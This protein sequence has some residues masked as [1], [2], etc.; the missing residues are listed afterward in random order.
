MNILLLGN[1]FD[2]N[3]LFPTSYIN[4]LNTLVFLINADR[5]KIQTIKDVFGNEDLQN[6]DSFIKKCYEKHSRIYDD[7]A[8][9]RDTIE[10]IVTKAEKNQWFKYLS[11]SV[12]VNMTWID[13]EKEIVRVLV[14]FN[15]FF[16]SDALNWVG[17]GFIFDFAAN[18]SKED[19]YIIECFSY[20]FKKNESI[21][22][23][24]SSM[25][26]IKEKYVREK[27]VGSGIYYLLADEIIS[28]LYE[29]LRELADLLKKY[30]RLFVDIPSREYANLGI[31]AQFN[32]LP[33]A[34]YIYSFNYTN[35]YEI[36]YSSN[37]VKH[38]HGNTNTN[39][40]LGVN[41]NKAD[42]IY[43]MDTTFLQFKKYFQRTFYSTDNSFLDE[44]Y[45][46]L[47]GKT[48]EGT[49]LYVVGHSLDVTD[50]DVIQLIFE[51]A[52]SICILYYDDISVKK[53]IK[54][55]V[56]IYG[57]QGLDKLRAEKKLNF[58]EQKD[59]VWIMPN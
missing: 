29:S 43:S 17:D 50:K 22:G 49:S 33:S 55:L 13:F 8:L 46:Q 20:F 32:S 56:E 48:L 21:N 38:I 44:V 11:E 36:L 15:N 25:I 40:V 47:R 2:L 28:D 14:A 6:K 12:A 45:S 42:D 30:L 4:F 23:I 31:K 10:K 7:I 27:I 54:N 37:N 16:E 19:G 39:I 1:G 34:K 53:Q 52:D 5:E 18:E 51:L 58:V 35:T 26:K 41:P 3:H 57:K 24:P 59:V 9:E